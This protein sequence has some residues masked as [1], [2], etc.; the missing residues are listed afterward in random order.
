MAPSLILFGPQAL[1]FDEAALDHLRLTLLQNPDHQWI[2][3]VFAELPH[4]FSVISKVYP[5]VSNGSSYQQLRDLNQWLSTGYNNRQ[6]LVLPNILLSPLVVTTQLVDYARHLEL[7]TSTTSQ[8]HDVYASSSRATET[9]GFCTG[10]LSALVV[11]S[12]ADREQFQKNGAAALRLAM[13]T[14]MVVDSQ[15][16]SSQAGESR[17]LATVWHSPEAGEA[18]SRILEDFSQVSF[19]HYHRDIATNAILRHIY[20]LP[21]MRIV[22]P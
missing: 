20:Q 17:S 11:S 6:K 3:D 2:L 10:L 5:S 8:G 14:G 16:T 12:S 18:I 4:W 21:M 7:G 13:L 9:L 1:S 19:L 22:Q 15:E